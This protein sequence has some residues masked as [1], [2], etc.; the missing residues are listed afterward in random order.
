[1]INVKSKSISIKAILLTVLLPIVVYA[2]LSCF[3]PDIYLQKSTFIMLLTQA[4]SNV[5]IGWSMVFGMSVGLF[6]FSVGARILL[7][8]FFGVHMSQR[9]GIAGFVIGCIVASI[10]IAILTGLIYA[11]LKIPS[12]ITGFSAL[13][14]FESLAVMYQNRITVIIGDDISIF[15]TSPG[16]YIVSVITFIAVYA[17]FNNTKFGYQIKAIGGNEAVAKSMGINSVKIKL[18]TYVV[19]GLILAFATM[20][21]VGYAGTITARTNMSSMSMCFT[22]MMGVMIG[23]YISSCNPVIGVFIGSFTITIVSSGLVALGIESRLQ[24]VVVGIF[25]I[26][27]IGWKTNFYRIQELIRK[28]RHNN[29]PLQE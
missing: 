11:S 10:I 19:G 8:A 5:I 17:L 13:L 21:K 27:F 25:L 24:N 2:V 6:D 14:I 9:F 29:I 28:R 26:L 4:L 12:I 23:L 22:P 16:I 3:R 1:M 20:V 7:A 18:L 15:G